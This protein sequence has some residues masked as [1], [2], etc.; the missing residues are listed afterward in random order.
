MGKKVAEMPANIIDVYRTAVLVA[1]I[2]TVVTSAS[3]H[4]RIARSRN[5]APGAAT[6]GAGQPHRDRDG[7][8][9]ATALAYPEKSRHAVIG[10]HC[11]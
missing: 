1:T 6:E 11:R 10:Q 3:S 5:H 4:A 2:Q 9:P 8:R 7:A